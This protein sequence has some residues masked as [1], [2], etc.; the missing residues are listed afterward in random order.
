M[1]KSSVGPGMLNSQVGHI[2]KDILSLANSFQ[3]CSFSHIVQ[4]GNAVAHV[5][6]QRV[7]LLFP[8]EV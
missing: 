5:L 7:R 3:S 2:I 6:A 8:L 1:I 4:Q